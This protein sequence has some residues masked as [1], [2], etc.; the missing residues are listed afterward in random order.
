TNVVQAPL[1]DPPGG[2]RTFTGSEKIGSSAAPTVPV[3]AAPSSRASAFLTD[4]PRP[5]NLARSVSHVTLPTASGPH[6]TTWAHQIEASV[7]DRGR[8]VASSAAL[9]S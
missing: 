9:A 8:R 5:M 2:I 1:V 3:S 4:R 7:A 6:A